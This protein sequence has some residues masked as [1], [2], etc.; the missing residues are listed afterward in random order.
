MRQMKRS[1]GAL[2][3]VALAAAGCKRTEEPPAPPPPPPMQTPPGG[4]GG[5]G[6]GGGAPLAA[7]GPAREIPTLEA[8][9][10]QDPKNAKAWIQL[11]ND[12]FDTHQAQKAIDAYSKAL[13]LQPN[14]PNVLTD[15]GVMYREVGQ[16]DKALANFEKANK[17]DPSHVTSLFNQGVV[18]AYDKKDPKKATAIWQRVM[19]AEPNGPNGAKARQA[20]ADLQAGGAPPR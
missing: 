3:A 20:I 1:L 7:N 4:G 17:A 10:A 9:V 5:M 12:Y 8:M 13:E 15:Q 18:W 19:Q 16:Y 2:A 6:G 14:D 11:G